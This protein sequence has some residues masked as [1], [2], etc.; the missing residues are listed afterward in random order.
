[1]WQHSNASAIGTTLVSYS[2]AWVGLDSSGIDPLVVIIVL[3]DIKVSGSYTRAGYRSSKVDQ[4][5]THGRWNLKCWGCL[6][7]LSWS[8]LASHLQLLFPHSFFPFLVTFSSFLATIYLPP[9]LSFFPRFVQV[10]C[11]QSGTMA[12][13]IA[14][15]NMVT[16]RVLCDDTSA[17][18]IAPPFIL[19][20]CDLNM[21][22]KDLKPRIAAYLNGPSFARRQRLIFRGKRFSDET[23]LRV[24]LAPIDVSCNLYILP[25]P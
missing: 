11:Q 18:M 16:I 8:E 10:F 9:A 25:P 6:I 23:T 24:A 19:T 22:V 20:N 4:V 12:A 5:S 1:M 3:D 7:V 17:T 15:A 13:P 14:E 21:R 2:I